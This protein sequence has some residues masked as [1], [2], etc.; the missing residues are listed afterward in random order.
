MLRR[1]GVDIGSI[2]RFPRQREMSGESFALAAYVL[3]EKGR[4]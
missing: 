2:F 3:L 1:L 4:D